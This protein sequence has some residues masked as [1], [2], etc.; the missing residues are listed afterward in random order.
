MLA[1]AWV[2]VILFCGFLCSSAIA[3]LSFLGIPVYPIIS[4]NAWILVRSWPI[5]PAE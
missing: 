5:V 3:S 1:A 2:A 4:R